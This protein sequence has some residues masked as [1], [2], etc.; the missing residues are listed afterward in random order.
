MV[1][2]RVFSLAETRHYRAMAYP[3]NGL[4]NDP[5]GFLISFGRSLDSAGLGPKTGQN[6]CSQRSPYLFMSKYCFVILDIHFLIVKFKKK[7]KFL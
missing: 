5:A 4:P 1:M 2:R 6:R 7:M 3:C